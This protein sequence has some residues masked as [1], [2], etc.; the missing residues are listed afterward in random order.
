MYQLKHYVNQNP[1]PPCFAGTLSRRE[2]EINRFIW[3]IFCRKTNLKPFSTGEKVA[4]KGS[5]EGNQG[6]I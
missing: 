6:V 3:A 5:D 1:S 4:P 2:R